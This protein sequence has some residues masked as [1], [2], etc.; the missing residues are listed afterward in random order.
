VLDAVATGVGERAMARHL[1]DM[2][3]IA[4]DGWDTFRLRSVR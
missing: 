2:R 3:T 1:R 4:L